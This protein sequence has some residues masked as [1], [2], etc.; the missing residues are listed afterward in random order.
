MRTATL[1]SAN[2]TLVRVFGAYLPYHTYEPMVRA[3]NSDDLLLKKEVRHVDHLPVERWVFDGKDFFIALDPTLRDIVE[4][5]I[6]ASEEVVR[7]IAQAKIN[8]LN[9][10][11]RLLQSRTIWDMIKLKFKRNKK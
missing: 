6:R 5:K 7:S 10:E 1:Y 9:D 4:C 8:K 11:I 3:Y 2:K